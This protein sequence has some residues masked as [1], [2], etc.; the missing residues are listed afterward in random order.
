M[1]RKLSHVDRGGRVVM[2][3][4][5]AKMPTL[6]RA[7]ARGEVHT[8]TRVLQELRRGTMQKGDVV[9]VARLAGIAA[10]K[11]T[12]T[13]I[14]LCHVLPL[15]HVEVD[16]DIDSDDDRIR[17]EAEVVC[18]AATGA[19]MEAIVA[20]LIAAATVYDM[21]KAMDRGMSIGSVELMQKSGGQSGP[22]RRSPAPGR[23]KLR[24]NP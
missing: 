5:S 10:A 19:E 20:V 23:T 11:Q 3:D 9:A 8:S 14:P 16:I 21:C 4:T 1:K 15:D 6:R 7:R 18:R 17:I 2:V 24:R 13:L 12:A 22:W